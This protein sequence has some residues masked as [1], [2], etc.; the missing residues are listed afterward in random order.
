MQRI[1]WKYL[2]PITLAATLA[3]LWVGAQRAGGLG[4]DATSDAV[5]G[6]A[7]EGPVTTHTASGDAQPGAAGERGVE[8]GLAAWR[9]LYEQGGVLGHEAAKAL[10][11][12]RRDAGKALAAELGALGAGGVPEVLAA[13]NASESSRE[14]LLLVESLGMNDAGEA[15][16]ALEEL[17]LSEDELFRLQEEAVRALARSEA[18][19]TTDALL[20]VLAQTDDDR[21]SQIAAQGLYGEEGALDALVDIARDSG[22]DMNTRLEAIHS[23]G[24]MDSTASD[25][26][27]ADLADDEAMEARVTQFAQKTIERAA[28]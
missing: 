6:A 13:Y 3:G 9:A 23:V 12:Q 25:D 7:A 5:A 1:P 20:D 19:G 22:D 24:G 14:Q 15:V 8:D 18:P 2:L 4:D 11:Q 21:I 28:N 26:A 17:A 27:L 10:V 16:S